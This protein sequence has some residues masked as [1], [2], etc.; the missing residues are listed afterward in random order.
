MYAIREL[1]VS[2]ILV[3]AIFASLFIPFLAVMLL[4]DTGQAWISRFPILSFAKHSIGRLRLAPILA[5]LRG[6]GENIYGIIL[7]AICAV[8]IVPI[9]LLLSFFEIVQPWLTRGPIFS[10]AKNSLVSSSWEKS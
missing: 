5:A 4:Y 6:A 3:A 7:I 8:L 10:S 1:V 9:F 2:V